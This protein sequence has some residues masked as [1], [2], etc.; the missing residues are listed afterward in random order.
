MAK[1][2]E[3]D[4]RKKAN[5]KYDDASEDP[6]FSI[7]IPSKYSGEVSLNH[8]SYNAQYP[9]YV[10]LYFVQETP[11]DNEPNTYHISVVALDSLS[12]KSSKDVNKVIHQILETNQV[13]LSTV[14]KENGYLQIM[15]EENKLSQEKEEKVFEDDTINEDPLANLAP[16]H[17]N[18]LKWW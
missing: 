9:A 7:D 1:L 4:I 16:D 15:V 6:F 11:I 12:V 5:N 18:T 14:N 10:T 13:N 8:A 3:S 2:I 17:P